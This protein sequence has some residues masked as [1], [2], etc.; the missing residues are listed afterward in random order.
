M[1]NGGIYTLKLK[2]LQRQAYEGR[3][4]CATVPDRVKSQHL[5]TDWYQ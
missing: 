1:H 5:V 3:D 2:L 4:D